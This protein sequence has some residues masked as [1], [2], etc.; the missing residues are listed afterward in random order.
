MGGTLFT[1][2][3]QPGQVLAQVGRPLLIRIRQDIVRQTRDT[4]REH[5]V[6]RK[7]KPIKTCEKRTIALN[8]EPLPQKV[9]KHGQIVEPQVQITRLCLEN[10]SHR[11]F[12]EAIAQIELP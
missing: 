3:T 8:R 1:H 10:L 4:A 5:G 6:Q 11:Y 7:I 2:L 9:A 12:A